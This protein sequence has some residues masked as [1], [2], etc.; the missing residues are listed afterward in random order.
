MKSHPIENPRCSP[1]SSNDLLLKRC[2]FFKTVRAYFDRQGF[3]EVETPSLIP[4]AD[5]S[6]HLA[7]FRTVYRSFQT[8]DQY[9]LFLRTSPEFAMKRLVAMGYPRI[10]QICK[11]FRDGESTELHNPEFTGLEW[12]ATQQDYRFLMEQTEGMVRALWPSGEILY[13]GQSYDV[14][15]PW[16]YLTIHQAFEKYA[17]IVL[18]TQI[19]QS[20]LA[21]ICLGKSLSVTE[22]DLWDDLFFKLFLT[23]IEPH[24][25]KQ[26]PTFLYDYPIQMAALSRSKPGQPS[27]A[28][29]V[30]LY[31]A[32]L[33]LANGYSE[34]TDWKEQEQ[35]WE[36][37]AQQRRDRGEMDAYPPDPG[38]MQ[39]LQAGMP[40]TAGIAVG[41]DRFLMLY[42]DAK[43]L[44]EVLAFPLR[45][46]ELHAIEKNH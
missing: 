25:G 24:L 27:I 34:L 12:Y 29:R 13:Q 3:L 6:P 9:R 30:E 11:F 1:G 44:D 21:Q 31:I 39:A 23:F 43:R 35:R 16:E 22:D 4:V 33:E 26:R 10:Y 5:P 28:E 45:V 8:D 15:A 7:S 41:L 14:R 36:A 2:Q 37:E 18:P 17:D 40:P 42:L 46:Q 38:L 32:G 20:D 19:K